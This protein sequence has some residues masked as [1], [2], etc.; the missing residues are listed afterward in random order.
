MTR[1]RALQEQWLR[2][3]PLVVMFE[4]YIRAKSG[5]K[6]PPRPG[7]KKRKADGTPIQD[8]N[9]YSGKRLAEFMK[10]LPTGKWSG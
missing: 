3:P 8:P 10:A 2:W 4:A 6:A 7:R 9:V 5:G 1:L